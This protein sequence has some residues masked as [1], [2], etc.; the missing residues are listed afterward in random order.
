MLHWEHPALVSASRLI[1]GAV[2]YELSL[3]QLKRDL[4]MWKSRLSY[5]PIV[6]LVWGHLPRQIVWWMRLL[7]RN[8]SRGLHSRSRRSKRPRDLGL[9]S[10]LVIFGDLNLS[11]IVVQVSHRWN[12]GRVLRWTETT[13]QDEYRAMVRKP[14]CLSSSPTITRIT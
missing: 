7:L 5:S 9:M 14:T 4:E 1:R 2:L 12:A 3:V 8:Q 13:L 10:V 6:I 11:Q